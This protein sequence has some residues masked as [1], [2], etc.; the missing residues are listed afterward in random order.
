MT[1]YTEASSQPFDLMDVRGVGRF[2]RWTHARTV[3]Q[4]PLLLLAALMVF[5]GLFGPQLA[6]KNLA[7]VLTWVHY[8]G[9]VVLALLLAGNLFCL[10]CPFMLVRNLARRFDAAYV[11]ALAARRAQE[12]QRAQDAQRAPADP[13]AGPHQAHDEPEK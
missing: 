13:E 6:P 12:I 3:L 4:V 8:R 1:S 10:A 7:T 5:D 11:E 9:L 2:L